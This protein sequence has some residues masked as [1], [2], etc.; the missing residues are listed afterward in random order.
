MKE[1]A[2]FFGV[3]RGAH[4]DNFQRVHFIGIAFAFEI[5]SD[6]PPFLNCF[7]VCNEEIGSQSAF[8]SFVDDNDAVFAE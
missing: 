1:F 2:E 4:D 8:V 7:K 3:K 6:V 5:Q